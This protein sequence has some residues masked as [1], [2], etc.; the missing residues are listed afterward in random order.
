MRALTIEFEDASSALVTSRHEQE[1]LKITIE[2]LH[3]RIQ[4]EV[5]SA[6]SIASAHLEET[7][8]LQ[9]ELTLLQARLKSCPP[10][11]LVPLMDK[12]GIYQRE[13]LSEESNITSL[14]WDHIE[15]LLIQTV[16]K[17]NAEVVEFRSQHAE[18]SAALQTTRQELENMRQELAE[19]CKA[20]VT[21]EQELS[22]AFASIEASKALLR[23]HKIENASR[24]IGAVVRG[25]GGLS[26]SDAANASSLAA[27]LSDD[28]SK[29]SSTY[30]ADA[31]TKETGGGKEDSAILRAVLDQ[32]DRMKKSVGD[33]E[34]ELLILRGQLERMQEEKNTLQ[35][36]NL[37]LY[38]RLRLLRVG[39]A[40]ADREETT[41]VT[42]KGTR[43]LSRRKGED[44][45]GGGMLRILGEDD[46]EGRYAANYEAQLDP[47][48]LQELDR[49]RLLSRLNVF[50]RSLASLV[51]LVMQDQWMRHAFL[52]YLLLVHIFAVGY[53]VIVLNPELDSEIAAI[54]NPLWAAGDPEVTDGGE[55]EMHPDVS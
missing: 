3:D 32:R 15:K 14:S 21:L 5:N 48:Q 12:L 25:N 35:H 2:S 43:T 36:D 10:T 24:P 30:A 28:G 27:L 18:Q 16:R 52:V 50:E 44:R 45:E 34:Q 55:W 33:K 17:A 47:F 49:L 31:A 38:K 54:E 4:K 13:A 1:E 37:E 39:S 41:S 11:D 19:K 26:I 9:T 7:Q 20:V 23:C 40:T 46:L 53:V 29:T 6:S 8:R 51:R 22:N 42:T